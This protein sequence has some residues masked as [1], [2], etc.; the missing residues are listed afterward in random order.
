MLKSLIEIEFLTP[1]G[2]RA[3]VF[4]PK[5]TSKYLNPKPG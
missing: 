1:K 3:G 4:R 2:Q 5:T